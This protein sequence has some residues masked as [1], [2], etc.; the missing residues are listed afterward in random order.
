[1]SSHWD[2]T[3]PRGRDEYRLVGRMDGKAGMWWPLGC[4]G[5]CCSAC[6]DATPEISSL[7][8]ERLLGHILRTCWIQTDNL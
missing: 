5:G 6:V 7:D 1:M 3:S 2:R 8:E 4:S